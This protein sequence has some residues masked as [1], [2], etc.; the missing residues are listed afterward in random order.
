MPCS[1]STLGR[2]GLLLSF[3]AE[4]TIVE[5]APFFVTRKLPANPLTLFGENVTLSR[6][7]SVRQISDSQ[8]GKK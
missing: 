5:S 4:S 1:G 8:G 2:N 6:V 7:S 3:G